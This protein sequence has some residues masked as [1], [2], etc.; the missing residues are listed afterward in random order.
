MTR[1]V[2]GARFWF[3]SRLPPSL[4]CLTRVPSLSASASPASGGGH[5]APSASLP[6]PQDVTQTLWLPR[7]AHGHRHGARVRAVLLCPVRLAVYLAPLC[8]YP[9]PVLPYDRT[10]SQGT[11]IIP[12]WCS[13]FLIE[14]SFLFYS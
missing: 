3:L 8:P 6:C 2:R 13:W 5:P 4:A 10:N 12:P 9:I 11:L 1:A 14:I 7:P